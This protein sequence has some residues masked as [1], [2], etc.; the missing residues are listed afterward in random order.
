MMAGVPTLSPSLRRSLQFCVLEP[1]F[2]GDSLISLHYEIR[3]SSD[4]AA[5]AFNETIQLPGT[6]ADAFDEDEFNRLL[7]LLAL[8]AATSYYKTYIP[9]T[10]VVDSG[11]T[12]GERTFLAAVL[13]QGLAEF[14]YRNSV[15]EALHPTISAPELSGAGGTGANGGD[16]RRL[17]VAVGGGK[18]S[19]VTIEA[20]RRLPVE[21]TLFSVNEYAPIR[22][23]AEHAGLG[24]HVA[25]R[26]LDRKLFE[27]N[28]SGALNGH[29]PVTAI[30][31]IIACLTAIRSGYDGVIFSNEASSSA[32]NLT[33]EGV[34]VNHQWS[35]G[36]EFE[37]LLRDLIDTTSV[38]YFSFLRPLTELAIMRGFA[39]L[40]S[41][42]SVFTSCNRA[43]HLDPAKRKL[44]CGDCPK[45][46]FVFLCLA[47]FLSRDALLEIFDGRDLFKDP[48]QREGFLELLNVG[49]RLKPFECV[50]E[51]SECR[52]AVSL[53]SKHPDWKGH[54][55][56]ADPDLAS[57]T[58]SKAEISELFAFHEP[59]FLPENY[60]RA[61][62]GLL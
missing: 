27:H 57:I 10:V 46:R 4:T 20:L 15:P 13:G 16:P 54:S 53:L 28:K 14:A 41:Y 62:R 34:D 8:A 32:G 5:V 7:R 25:S 58:L 52:A 49:H 6:R 3:D 1:S 19:I 31:S 29:V 36:I 60:E 42:H 47:P 22:A 40:P 45:C 43:F 59:H 44:W 26:S 18:D 56:L 39:T 11:L 23:T 12:G 51:P 24:L 21:I 30:N 35:K 48:M 50:G 61:V 9:S 38:T 2:D 33:W 37:S 17:L 55:F